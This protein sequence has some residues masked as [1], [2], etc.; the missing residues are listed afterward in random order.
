M[1]SPDRVPRQI[2]EG[3]DC[4][5]R[6]KQM[7]LVAT[8][9]WGWEEQVK[10]RDNLRLTCVVAGQTAPG[11]QGRRNVHRAL[12]AQVPGPQLETLVK[13]L[14]LSPCLPPWILRKF[15]RAVFAD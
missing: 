11:G 8:S 13:T 1:A 3:K 4:G 14:S 9:P 10:E 15:S 5:N 7:S 2:V 12:S 6:R